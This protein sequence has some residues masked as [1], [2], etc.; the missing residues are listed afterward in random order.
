MRS[1][2]MNVIY[3]SQGMRYNE[4]SSIFP[5]LQRMLSLHDKLHI[6]VIWTLDSLAILVNI[7]LIAAI[8]LRLAH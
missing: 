5:S 7:V 2:F 3:A 8:A 1:H 4:R 6:F